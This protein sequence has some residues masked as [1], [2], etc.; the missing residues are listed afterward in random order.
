MPNTNLRDYISALEKTGDVVH[1]TEEVDWEL[2]IG[3]IIS[4]ACELRAPAPL[5]HKI[6]DYASGFRMLGAPLATHRR[7]AVAFGK[8]PQTRVRELHAEYESRLAQPI[9]PMLVKTGPC[10]EN[11]ITGDDIDI[12]QFPAPY[13]H[14]GDGNRFIGTWHAVITKDPDSDW[15]NWGMYRI[16]LHSRKYITGHWHGA[17]DAGRLLQS[18]YVPKKKPMP[19]A[20]AIGLDPLCCL[21]AVA[22]LGP[23]QSE[24]DYA[25]GLRRSPVE[26]VK[27]ET[28]DLY[29][30][31]QAEFILEGEILP[32]VKVPDGPF[33]DFPGYHIW[34][35]GHRPARLN[36]ITF[37][38]SPIFTVSNLGMPVDDS[39]IALSI[40]SSLAIKKELKEKGVPVTDV[41]V[42]PETM[43]HLAVVGVK[44]VYSTVADHVASIID[45]RAPEF[46]HVVM[47]MDEDV[48]VFN[49]DEVLHAFVTRCNPKRG[50]KINPRR[51]VSG[52]TPFLNPR[53]RKAMEGASMSFDCT[54]PKEMSR[55]TDIPPRISFRELEPRQ[56]REK[57]LSKWKEYGYK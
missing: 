49:W 46:Q 50:V 51:L 27:C 8:S 35:F 9:K 7:L 15:V 1:I 6:K 25:G 39:D 16:G 52:L 45:A 2:E 48:D 53:E 54:W 31:A 20:I 17:T 40:T 13:E 23:G 3:A 30:P 37:R 41:Y 19:V 33:G 26:L 22:P 55:D 38:N 56:I 34:G 57:V 44:T 43:G 21:A 24:V 32:D 47:V 36:A 28:S 14:E 29:V 18:K 42:P 12:F 5:F 10:K 11:I 4:H